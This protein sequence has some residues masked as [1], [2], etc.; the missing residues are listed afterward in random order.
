MYLFETSRNNQ[1]QGEEVNSG[2]A[3]RMGDQC[4]SRIGQWSQYTPSVEV[5]PPRVDPD[6]WTQKSVL[7]QMAQLRQELSQGRLTLG[8][9]ETDLLI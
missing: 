8:L 9:D 2:L 5:N 6:L 3:L 1:F 4:L 7:V